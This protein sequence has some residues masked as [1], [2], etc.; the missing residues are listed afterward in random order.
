MGGKDPAKEAEGRRTSLAI[1]QDGRLLQLVTPLGKDFLLLDKFR[2]EEGLSRLFHFELDLLHEEPA[3]GYQPTIVNADLILGK[4]VGI[5]LVQPDGLERYFSGI[6]SHFF[7]GNRDERFSYYRAVVVPQFWLLTQRAQSRIFQQLSVPEILT[8]VLEGLEVSYE[9]QGAFYPREYCAQYRETDFNFASRLMEEEGIYYFFEQSEHGHRLILANTPASHRP[10]PGQSIVPFTLE[11]PQEEGFESFVHSWL[12][13]HQLQTGKYTL[14]DH[15]FELPHRKLE[16]EQTSRFIV[17]NNNQLEVFDFP[18]GYATR[19]D[20]VNKSGGSQP[21]ELNKIFEDNYRTVEIRM[22]ELDATYEVVTAAS[23]CASLASGHRFTLDN[24]PV[25]ANNIDHVLTSI[26]HEA[27]QSPAYVSDE[28]S[29]R[30]YQNSFTCIAFGAGKAPFRP[31]RVT[32]KP[33]V[34]GS[35]TAVVVGPSGE[36]IFVDKYGRVKVQFHWD[37]EGQADAN[38][39]CWIRVAQGQAGVRWGAAFWPRIGQ[40]VV[41][42]F[43][44][45]DPDRPIII[46]SVFN[47]SEMP[48]YTMPD[49]KTKTVIFK[50]QSSK[51]GGGFNELRIEDKKGSEQIFINAEKD[52]DL[53]VKNDSKETIGH[54]RHLMVT[55]DQLEKVAGDKHLQVTGDRNEKV[56]G[57]FSL[58]AG[59]DVQ[60][61]VGSKYALESGME[62]HL[63]SGANLVLET[64]TTLTL[65]VGGNF[66]NINSAGIFIKGN[67]VMINSGGAAGSGAGAH[68]GTPKDPL[69]ADKAEPGALSKPLPPAPPLAAVSYGSAALAMLRAAEVG[70]PFCEI[71]QH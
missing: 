71:C 58:T 7:Q 32:S 6:V 2:G 38:S 39:S 67:M 63:K 56:S 21:S 57:T 49:E 19:F 36:E 53:R 42:D 35:Q 52:K 60:E 14:W 16:A 3:H 65:K 26:S 5:T 54:D 69:E 23:N 48:P 28:E 1:T 9:I 45:G 62:I 25:Q 50:S 24:H 15:N 13:A 22:Q 18:G 20:G 37:R 43:L 31:P 51:G 34:R 17:G 44:E 64:G 29:D 4:P 66:I 27:V 68:P 61:K 47:A 12:I 46:G 30:I 70:A 55:H 33:T 41:I 59:Q 40:E 8:K 10:C 11:V